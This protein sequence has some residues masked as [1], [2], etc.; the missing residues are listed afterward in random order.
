MRKKFEELTR[1]EMLSLTDKDKEFYISYALADRG[2][3]RPVHPGAQPEIP[4]FPAPTE[5]VY[6]CRGLIVTDKEEAEMIL[7]LKTVHT[8]DYKSDYSKKYV[9]PVKAADYNVSIQKSTYYKKEVIEKYDDEIKK[10]NKLQSQY[11]NDL[12]AYDKAMAQIREE[13]QFIQNMLDAVYDEFYFVERA[14]ARYVELL[15]LAENNVNIAINFFKKAFPKE[16]TDDKLNSFF[17]ENSTYAIKAL[18]YVK[19]CELCGAVM[20]DEEAK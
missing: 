11:S 9:K 7:N 5:V 16:E 12:K 1:E 20:P 14:G 15:E 18:T 4:T 3:V 13:T 2:I 10:A 17:E 6:E 19:F 8:T